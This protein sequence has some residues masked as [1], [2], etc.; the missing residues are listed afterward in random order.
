M[1]LSRGQATPFQPA[2]HN[3]ALLLAPLNNTILPTHNKH[4][5]LRLLSRG[6]IGGT[7]SSWL[8]SSV[9]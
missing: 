4:G 2:A 7:G 1:S 6:G 8:P 3:M 5:N 9:E